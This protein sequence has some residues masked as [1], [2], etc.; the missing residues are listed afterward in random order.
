MESEKGRKGVATGHFQSPGVWILHD[1]KNP[2]QQKPSGRFPVSTPF[3]PFS[4]SIFD[5]P[6]RPPQQIVSFGYDVWMY[7]S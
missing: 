6:Q 3:L 4:L 2:T 7:L 1:L 5:S